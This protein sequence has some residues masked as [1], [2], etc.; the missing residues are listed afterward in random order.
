MTTYYHIQLEPNNIIENFQPRIPA[1]RYEYEDATIPRISLSTS[2]EGC[3]TAVPWG[4]RKLEIMTSEFSDFHSEEEFYLVFRVYEF[5]SSTIQ[6]GNLIATDELLKRG[7][8]MDANA[9]N[10]VWVINQDLKPTNTYLVVLEEY[11]EGVTDTFTKEFYNTEDDEEEFDFDKY[12]IGSPT[13]I[14]SIQYKKYEKLEDI[15]FEIE[16][17][18]WLIRCQELRQTSYKE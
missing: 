3:L 14:E 1:L 10:E 6:E 13:I 17:T 16:L 2:I 18:E 7:L 5:D 8:V 9:S 12:Y 15:P 11:F 4:G